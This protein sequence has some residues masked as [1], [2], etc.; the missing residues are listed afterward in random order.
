MRGLKH[1]SFIP[2]NFLVFTFVIFSGIIIGLYF[3]PS[4]DSMVPNREVPG[5]VRCAQLLEV[6]P[7]HRWL[8]FQY[9]NHKDSAQCMSVG[10]LFISSGEDDISLCFALAIACAYCALMLLYVRFLFTFR[11]IA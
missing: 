8:C 3:N 5:G 1:I 2:V 7:R 9:L 4:T 6:L 11:L 10:P